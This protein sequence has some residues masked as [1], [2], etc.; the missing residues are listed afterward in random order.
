MEF[1]FGR[2]VTI[3]PGKYCVNVPFVNSSF[4]ATVH[5]QVPDDDHPLTN[6][7]TFATVGGR[8]VGCTSHDSLLSCGLRT[9]TDATC[10]LDANGVTHC[11]LNSK[12]SE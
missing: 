9:G 12:R 8:V 3:E 11:F 6:G 5:Q 10:T 1:A 7:A 4:M 2:A